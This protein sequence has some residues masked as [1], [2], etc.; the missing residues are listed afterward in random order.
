VLFIIA[1]NG[2][3]ESA[4]NGIRPK[5]GYRRSYYENSEYVF[6]G[7]AKELRNKSGPAKR[8][9]VGP[10]STFFVIREWSIT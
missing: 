5:T 6:A 9:S 7:I 2:N 4:K 1:I 8:S 10:L 3:H